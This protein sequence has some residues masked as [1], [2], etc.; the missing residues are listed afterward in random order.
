MPNINLKA[1]AAIEVLKAVESF[2]KLSASDLCEI[3]PFSRSTVTSILKVYH[4]QRKIH[5]GGWKFIKSVGW[6]RLYS[7]GE[8]SDLP[9]PQYHIETQEVRPIRKV[10]EVWPRCDIAASWLRNPI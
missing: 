3:I 1:P 8:G 5:I 2:D 6:A 4:T 9:K 10:K 7:I